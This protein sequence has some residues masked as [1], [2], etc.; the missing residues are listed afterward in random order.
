[1]AGFTLMEV[2]AVV[3]ILAILVAV[4][5]PSYRRTVE[6]G[7][8]QEAQDLLMTVYYGER[9]YFFANDKYD[10]EQP[11][12]GVPACMASWREIF[13]DDPNLNSIPVKF[14]VVAVGV[15]NAATFTATADRGNGKSMSIDQNR[16]WCGGPD[17]T[18]CTG[19]PKP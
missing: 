4:A 16:L 9:A 6:R 10:N 13:T 2:L 5:I 18:S 3:I 1:M 8:W 14:D 17:I 12:N 11:C 19:W 7:Y 15:G